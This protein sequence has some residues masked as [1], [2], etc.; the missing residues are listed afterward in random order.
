MP[1]SAT[2]HE[3]TI[4]ENTY[5]I[6][7]FNPFVALEIL[8]DLQK[9]FAGPL[10]SQLDGKESPKDADGNIILNG[11]TA[12]N[13]MRSFESLSAKLDGKTLRNIAERL[14]DKEYISVSIGGDNPRQLNQTAQGL[15]FESVSDIFTLC[16]EILKFNYS[17]VITRLSSPT[18]PVRSLL[19]K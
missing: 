19:R 15:A 11:E 16:W 12:N 13:L 14:I 7:R 5:F 18:G 4:G 3:V 6:R 10:I 8:G 9:Q 2:T 17:E 1:V